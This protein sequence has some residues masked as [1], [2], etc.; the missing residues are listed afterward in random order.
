MS[1]KKIIFVLIEHHGGKAHP[2][3]WEL[4]GKAR[5]LA[6][7]LENSEVWGVLLGEGLESVA[8]EAIQRGADKVLYVKNREFNTYVNY[9]YKKALVDMVRKYRPEIFLIGA[10]LEGRELAGMVA[11]EL[12]TGLTADCTGLD[13]IPDKKLLAMTRPT[14]GGNLM[15]TIMC[16]DHR[17][18][19]ATVRPGVMKELPPDPERTGEII[20]EEYDLGTFDKL[21]EIL[22]TIPLQTQVNLEYAPVVV[23]GGKGVG[24]P[25]GFKKLKELADLLGGEVGASR[26]AVKAGWISPEH[27]VGQTGKTVRPV[28]YFACGIS[29]AIQHVVGIKESEIIVAINI[30]EKA[31]IFDIADIGIV[32]DLHKVV[33]ALTAKLRELLNKS[34]VKK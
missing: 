18:Q 20:E 10:T 34:G 13:I 31:P 17:P 32:G 22:E 26:A 16:P 2:V 14:F 5:D 3:S 1:E 11:T 29:G 9:L 30:D 12:E 15:A 21:I 4:I 33:P 28:L 6:S 23:A 7:K 25:E 24:G 8:K 19:M 27:Q